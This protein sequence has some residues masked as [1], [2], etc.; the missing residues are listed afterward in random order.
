MNLKQTLITIVGSILATLAGLFLI[1][2]NKK[3]EQTPSDSLIDS[4]TEA[5]VDAITSKPASDI[6]KEDVSGKEKK[7][8]EGIV[9]TQVDKAMKSASKYK[10]RV[11]SDE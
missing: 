10:R 9:D 2:F 7:V 8:A 6:Y 4:K 5:K 11:N 3:I 1:L